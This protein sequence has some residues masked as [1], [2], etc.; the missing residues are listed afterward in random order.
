M[1][2]ACKI[3]SLW[4]AIAAAVVAVPVHSAEL[5]RH[6]V[7]PFWPKPLPQNW[8]LGHV[9]GVAIDGQDNVWIL[10]RPRSLADDEK[11]AATSPPSPNAARQRR[12]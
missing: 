1:L 2:R 4:S 8:I 6:A 5:P 11:A 10:Q 9:A 7:D 12:Q 3:V